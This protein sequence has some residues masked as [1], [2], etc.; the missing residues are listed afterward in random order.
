M[1]VEVEEKHEPGSVS[2]KQLNMVGTINRQLDASKGRFIVAV[3]V[4]SRIAEPVTI[5]YW[6]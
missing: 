5:R 6:L 3:A 2:N 4:D 1:I